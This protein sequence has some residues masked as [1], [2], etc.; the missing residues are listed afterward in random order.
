M[1]KLVVQTSEILPMNLGPPF[2]SLNAFFSLILFITF[3]TKITVG[4]I[5]QYHTTGFI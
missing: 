4:N 3:N 2:L 1:N 5:L